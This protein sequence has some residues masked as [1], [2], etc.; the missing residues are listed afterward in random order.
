[1]KLTHLARSFWYSNRI[2]ARI[3]QT[4]YP[5]NYNE[6]TG[7]WLHWIL[8]CPRCV[9]KNATLWPFSGPGVFIKWILRSCGRRRV[10]RKTN[11]CQKL[12]QSYAITCNKTAV[13][14]APRSNGARI[15]NIIHTFIMY[16]FN[17]FDSSYQ[18]D[19]N[20]RYDALSCIA[21]FFRETYVL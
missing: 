1:M 14:P 2:L 21:I 20:T 12:K 15:E 4:I 6:S 3:Y 8:A 5:D 13:W 9:L 19:T 7:L 18:K 10:P 11:I 16:A 17:D